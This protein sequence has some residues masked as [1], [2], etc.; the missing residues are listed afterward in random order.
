MKNTT[1]QLIRLYLTITTRFELTEHNKYTHYFV[2]HNRSHITF[3]E[4]VHLLFHM[5][6]RASSDLEFRFTLKN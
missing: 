2:D 1:N 6:P 3:S 5:V 4:F